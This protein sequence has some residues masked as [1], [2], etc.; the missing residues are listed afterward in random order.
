MSSILENTALTKR[1]RRTSAGDRYRCQFLEP[2]ANPCRILLEE[3][4]ALGLN[5][6]D[7]IAVLRG[8]AALSNNSN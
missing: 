4:E 3:A 1:N 7:V 6:D 8:Q 2:I 5:L